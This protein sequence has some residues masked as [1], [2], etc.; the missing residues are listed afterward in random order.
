LLE[1]RE[2]EFANKYEVFL[3]AKQASLNIGILSALIQ[4]GVMDAF[5]DRDRCRLVLEAQV[6]NILTDREK[7]N[8]IAIGAKYNY[9]ILES[10]SMCVKEDLIGDDN[11]KMF[12]EKRFNTFKTKYAP[13]KDIYEKNKKH[14]K[15]ANW[16]FESKLLGYSYSENIRDIFKSELNGDLVS[17][18]QI[19]EQ[20]NNKTIRFVGTVNDTISRTSANGNKYARFDLSDEV[21]NVT[22]LMMDSAREARYTN[23]VK[24]GKV[25][26]KKGGVVILVGKKNNDI[27]IIEKMSLLEDKIYMKLSEVK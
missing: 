20:E 23:Y 4:A 26:P 8:F 22:A 7:R 21:G 1:F 16:H 5:V 17:S 10:I 18:N 3:A 9:D 25:L 12:S 19:P 6:F 24:S 27:V 13:Y 2:K 11:K 15:F 14:L